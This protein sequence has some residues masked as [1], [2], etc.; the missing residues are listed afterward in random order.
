MI[1]EFL[2]DF[3]GTLMTDAYVAYKYFNNLDKCSYLCCWAYVR[4]IF[5]SALESYRDLKAQE[6]I[7]L[8]GMFYKI[9]VECIL[10]HKTGDE[11]ITARKL[12]SVPVLNELKQKA[13][14]LLGRC[15]KKK[16]TYRA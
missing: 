8:I 1:E 3:Q 11:V 4:R 13:E 12:E 16:K 15:E 5:V 14:M 10:L 6:Y 2:A 7:E 9:E